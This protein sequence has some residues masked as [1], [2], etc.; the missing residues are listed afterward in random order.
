[1]SRSCSDSLRRHLSSA[2]PRLLARAPLTRIP[3]IQV[4]SDIKLQKEV[5]LAL[6][7]GSTVFIN[8]LAA[9]SVSGFRSARSSIANAP[10]VLPPAEV[11]MSRQ[12]RTTRR[13]RR[14]TSS[15]PLSNSG[16]TTAA[17]CTV[18]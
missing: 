14:H 2:Y 12:R 17:N 13:S 6:V 3:G 18:S 10:S 16:G 5:P 9:L 1:M 11:T 8:Y 7:K 4:P 15:T